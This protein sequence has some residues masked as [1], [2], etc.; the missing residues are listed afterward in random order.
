MPTT[1]SPTWTRLWGRKDA[2]LS[3]RSRAAAGLTPEDILAPHAPRIVALAQKL[4]GIVRAA[5]PAAEERAYP[6]WKAIG[7]VHPRAGYVCGLFPF[8]DRVSLGF[9]FGVLLP[10]PAGLLRAGP[11]GGK[12]VRYVEV[13]RATDIHVGA[14]RDLLSAAVALKSGGEERGR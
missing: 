9:E 14:L 5:L 8:E 12:K 13:R 6:G 4:R 11:S 3:K 2:E 1:S 7:Y 10:D